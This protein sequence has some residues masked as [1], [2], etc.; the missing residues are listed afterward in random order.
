LRSVNGMNRTLLSTA[1]A[2][3]T[4]AVLIAVMVPLRDH[5]SVATTALILVV[6]VV[7][8][9]V[10]G[11]FT[12]G[13]VSVV[14]G[15]LAYDFFFIP[16][17][18]TFVVGAP[19]NWAALAVYVA[20][21]LPVG[22]VEAGMNAARSEARRQGTE[23]K[24]LFELS[25]QLVEDRPLERLLSSI[26]TT[27][28]QVFDARQVAI[29]LPAK[30]VSQEGEEPAGSLEVV[31]TAG[32][33]LAPED[34]ARVLAQ[35]EQS[36]NLVPREVENGDFLTLAL[37][38]AGRPV[39]LLVLSGPAVFSHQHEPLH[40]FA[41]H[42]ALAVERAQLREQALQARVAEEMGRL[43]KTLVA[44]VSHDLRAPLAAIKASSSTLA[45][46]AIELDTK[47]IHRLTTMIDHQAD[48]LADLVKNLL[49]MSRIQAGVLKPRTTI[50][51]VDDLVTNA[52]DEP[53]PTV[54]SH[55]LIL[56]SDT[57]VPPVDVDVTLITRVLVNL[58][59]NAARYGP[60]GSS[61]VVTSSRGD[62][63]TVLVS[64][65]D[66]GPG[67]DKDRRQEIFDG[68][69][70]RESDAGAGLGL[71]IAKTFVE[72][73]GQC[74][75]VDDGPDGRGAVFTVSLPAAKPLTEEV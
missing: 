6:P 1:A 9:V 69:A 64:V 74:I 15:F 45:E 51:S 57:N 33:P 36:V 73:H 21:M 52:L 13:V 38:A 65:R 59:E 11:G 35:H 48:K 3:G 27:V 18:R 19:Q 22:R 31:A 49:D 43:A 34:L 2:L 29:L 16:P 68:F 10:F 44:A 71:A 62:D 75:W 17:Y 66:H 24:E 28:S 56:R 40:L 47:Q 70:R 23:I 30:N 72:A 54:R 8:G 53:S 46:P 63:G 60:K 14:V 58:V 4:M 25:D 12:A 7:I 37:S 20:V 50:I 41:N 61:I 32:Q 26:V 42:I 5:L 39:G 55:P 67:V